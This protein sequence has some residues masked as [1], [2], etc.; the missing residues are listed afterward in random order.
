[1]KMARTLKVVNVGVGDNSSGVIDGEGLNKVI[2]AVAELMTQ[3]RAFADDIKELCKDA[4]EKGIAT[5][6]AIR[7]LARERL[8]DP[9]VVKAHLDYMDSLRAAL[10]QFAEEPLG[11]AAL[12]AAAAAGSRA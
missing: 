12:A 11:A 4:A 7:A 1:M 3:Q 10:A 9:E 8:A 5:S 2:D 6:K